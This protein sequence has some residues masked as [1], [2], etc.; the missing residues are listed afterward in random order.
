M[1]SA[2]QPAELQSCCQR[3]RAAPG[4][5]ERGAGA[6]RLQ[7]HPCAPCTPSPGSTP[8]C[9]APSPNLGAVAQGVTKLPDGLTDIRFPVL[10]AA[11]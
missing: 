11:V 1:L 8:G 9:Q 10:H 3:R 4:C 5:R 2:E 6:V 7:Q